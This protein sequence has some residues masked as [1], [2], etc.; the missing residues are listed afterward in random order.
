MAQEMLLELQVS[1]FLVLTL[2]TMRLGAC[3]VAGPTLPKIH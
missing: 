1:K 2:V 3:T